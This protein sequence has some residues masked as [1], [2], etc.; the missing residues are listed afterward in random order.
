[1]RMAIALVERLNEVKRPYSLLSQNCNTLLHSLLEV[2]DLAVPDMP[3]WAPGLRRILREDVEYVKAKSHEKHG[4]ADEN[5][6]TQFI[7]YLDKERKDM[8]QKFGDL[9]EAAFASSSAATLSLKPRAA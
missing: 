9:S 1:M 7:G 3:R 8:V 2:M 6:L 4:C 5:W